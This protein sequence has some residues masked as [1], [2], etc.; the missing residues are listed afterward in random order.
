MSAY[1]ELLTER[2]TDILRQWPTVGTATACANCDGIFRQID[3][4]PHCGSES[5]Y[6]LSAGPGGQVALQLESMIG[7]LDEVLNG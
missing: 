5:M 3:R 1:D 4:C 2:A 7:M 6:P